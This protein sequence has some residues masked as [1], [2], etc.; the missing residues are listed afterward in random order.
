ML[1]SY[2]LLLGSAPKFMMP[3]ACVDRL[4]LALG[5]MDERKKG[6]KLSYA[7]EEMA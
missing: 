1:I 3:V 7:S 2:D 6:R 4:Y 5:W